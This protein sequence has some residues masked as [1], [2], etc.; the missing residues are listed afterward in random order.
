MKPTI[1][2]ILL[3]TS[4][5]SC[6][7]YKNKD[8]EGNW[9]SVNIDQ[10]SF[11]IYNE[12]SIKDSCFN[13]VNEDFGIIEDKFTVENNYIY[14]IR[15]YKNFE[16]SKIT[17]LDSHSIYLKFK[18]GQTLHLEKLSQNSKFDCTIDKQEFEEFQA[19]QKKIFNE[20]KNR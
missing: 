16:W 12:Y 13:F 15:P 20:V 3:I 2:Y 8:L 11:L 9:S 14:L 19:R 1:I 5:T 7:N 17:K 6:L 10:D 4:L 18:D